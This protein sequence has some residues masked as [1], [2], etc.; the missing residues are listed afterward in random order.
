[1]KNENLCKMGIAI[2]VCRWYYNLRQRTELRQT[3]TDR[4]GGAKRAIHR[5]QSS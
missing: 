5:R 3:A 1:M 2:S 4:A